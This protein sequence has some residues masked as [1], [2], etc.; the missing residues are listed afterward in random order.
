MAAITRRREPQKRTLL[1][2]ALASLGGIAC[3][4]AVAPS[5]GETTLGGSVTSSGGANVVQQGG[6]TGVTSSGGVSAVLQGGMTG[7]TSSGGVAAVGGAM[8]LP[9]CSKVVCPVLPSTCTLVVQPANECCA[10]CLSN[11]CPTCGAI[12]CEAGT[13]AETLLGECC[14]QCVTDPPNAC[15]EGQTSYAS[16]RSQ[17]I[18]KYSSVKCNNSAECEIVTENNACAWTCGNP[19]AITMVN[20][21]KSNLDSNAAQQCAS[22]AAPPPVMCEKMVPAC[23]NGKCVAASPN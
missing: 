10:T 16:L 4:G 3:G 6:T 21:L 19:I 18:E 15:E 2:I 17:L 22:C 8:A 13:H 20:N 12:F 14:A 9:T 1:S 23:F 5:S 7:I 11:P